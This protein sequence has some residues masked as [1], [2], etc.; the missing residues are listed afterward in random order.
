MIL[1]TGRSRYI[2]TSAEIRRVL[3][4]R[5]LCFCCT[6]TSTKLGC[7]R[8]I[9]R[10]FTACCSFFLFPMNQRQLERKFPFFVFFF[11][12][13]QKKNRTYDSGNMFVFYE[14][15]PR[16]VFMSRKNVCLFVF[17]FSIA[18]TKKRYPCLVFPMTYLSHVNCQAH[19]RVGSHS[20]F[21]GQVQ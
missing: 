21:R 12:V 6:P 1:A 20:E 14:R 4:F 19:M 18:C 10:G 15:V 11:L 13:Y 9:Q 2:F 17:L 16:K 8:E 7:F 3:L 5:F